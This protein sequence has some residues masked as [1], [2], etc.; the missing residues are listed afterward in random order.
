MTRTRTVVGY[1]AAMTLLGGGL[2]TIAL[3]GSSRPSSLATSADASFSAPTSP[4]VTVC[5]N[6][7]LLTGPCIGSRRCGECPGGGQQCALRQHP[8]GGHDL[9]VRPG[10]P[11][12]RDR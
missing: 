9:L 10:Y 2:S 3:L 11:H 6:S 7:S 1:L 4:P 12:A 5:G 8:P